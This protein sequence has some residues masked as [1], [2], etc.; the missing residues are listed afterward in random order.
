[1]T[2]ALI[3]M[4]LGL[5][6]TGFVVVTFVVFA[7]YDFISMAIWAIR[8]HGSVLN[9]WGEYSQECLKELD[10]TYNQIANLGQ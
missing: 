4:I 3:K 5:L 2:L 9:T 7:P 10:K 1:M 6:W 8:Y